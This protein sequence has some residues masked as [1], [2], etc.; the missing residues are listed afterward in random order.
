MFTLL[1]DIMLL[2][3]KIILTLL[4]LF[5]LPAYAAKVPDN[6]KNYVNNEFP[7]TNF[8]FD[9]VIILPDNTIYLPLF[10]A[11][12][13]E[14][15]T[16]EI[17]STVPEGKKLSDKPDVVIFNS[18]FVLL[19]VLNEPE[20]KKTVA[21]LSSIPQEVRSGLLPQDMLVPK[22]LVIPDNLKGIIGNLEISTVQ[23]PGLRVES[24]KPVLG[25]SVADIAQLKDKAFYI[26]TCYSKNIRVINTGNQEYTLVQKNIPISVQGYND[27][28]LLVTSY[29]KSSLDVIS[30]Q[31]DRVI[32]QIPFKT[33]PYEIIVDT[34]GKQAYVSSAEDSSIY[35]VNLETMT[36]S[37]Q[38]KISGM[39]EKLTLSDDGTKIFY[40][41]KNS[42]DIWAIELNNNYLLKDI[43]KFPN[44]SK[45]AYANNKI[46]I[47]SRTK[48]HLAIIDYDTVGLI[49]EVEIAE[50]PVDMAVYG[51]NLF[52]LGAAQNEIQV[53]N[54]ATDAVTDT[55]YLNTNG[56]STKIYPVE[57]TGLALVTDT[58][59]SL[60]TVFDLVNKKVL[61]TNP[62]DIPVSSIVVME[63]INR[64]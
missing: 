18:D 30:L 40:F 57:G 28:F 31:D 59:A 58:K 14:P 51:G 54:T 52:I 64:W 16:M 29:E 4:I 44:V 32:K 12:I 61:K 11:K 21:K 24:V 50:K 60:Y 5:A 13:I 34:A 15:D 55:I 41:D 33:Q 42:R 7:G 17:T 49:A 19:K 20:G 9:G 53:L 8:R 3:R 6:V 48:N 46:Y 56:F 22:G 45:I 62:L 36:L 2:M 63:R 27:K 38:I 39:C 43:G 47:T 25:S 37:K 26:S 35:V 10:P 23:D 1:R